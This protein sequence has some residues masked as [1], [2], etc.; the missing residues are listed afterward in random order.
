MEVS[1]TTLASNTKF[2]A[3]HHTHRFHKLLDIQNSLKVV[4]LRVIVYYR[5]KSAKGWLTGWSLGK[6]HVCSFHCPFL[7]E[8]QMV[9]T[10]PS[11]HLPQDAEYYEPGSLP[12]PWCPEFLVELSQ[13]HMV[14]CLCGS[15]FQRVASEWLR[16]VTLN[17]ILDYWYDSRLLD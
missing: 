8:S 12:E 13:L 2:G 10:S 7:D 17:H 6:V 5:L 4:I 1:K 3:P 11:N 16:A 9:L 15:P 14:D